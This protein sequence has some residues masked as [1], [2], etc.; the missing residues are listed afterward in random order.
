[1][2]GP[3]KESMV[4][5]DPAIS[6]LVLLLPEFIFVFLKRLEL[7]SLVFAHEVDGEVIS[8][9]FIILQSSNISGLDGFGR[10]ILQSLLFDELCKLV[11]CKSILILHVLI[12]HFPS[13]LTS[14]DFLD[15]DSVLGQFFY[16]SLQLFWLGQNRCGP[17]PS[18]F[19]TNLKK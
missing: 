13:I 17:Y 19:P 6:L 3:L 5:K 4:G 9:K 10:L 11:T 1:M 2:Y 15:L 7:T 12:K 8:A 18:V 14:S 16:S